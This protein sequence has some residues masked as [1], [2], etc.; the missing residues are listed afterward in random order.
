MSLSGPELLSCKVIVIAS[1]TLPVLCDVG[2]ACMSFTLV[3]GLFMTPDLSVLYSPRSGHMRTD[4]S[5]CSA[6]LPDKRIHTVREYRASDAS[7]WYLNN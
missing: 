1:Y 5:T 6:G 7:V 2:A 4:H 3:P